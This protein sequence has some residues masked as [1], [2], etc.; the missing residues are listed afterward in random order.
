MDMIGLAEWFRRRT[1]RV[2]QRPVLTFKGKTWG[3]G[4][5][6][7][8]IEQLATVFA[9]GGV[10]TGDRVSYLGFNHSMFL[11]ALFATARIGAIF[12][13][14]NFR[15]TSHEMEFTIN[16]AESHTLLVNAEHLA[17]VDAVRDALPCRRYICRENT[18]AGGKAVMH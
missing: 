17:I 11:V 18:A 10:R 3:W 5:M 15:L 14:L 13:P 16:D 7:E 8:S 6:Q 12:V 2:P 1:V 9:D 4:E